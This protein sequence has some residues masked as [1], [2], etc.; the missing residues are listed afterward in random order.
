M[1]TVLHTSIYL[2]A[3]TQNSAREL[4]K[5]AQNAR[6]TLK[7][8]ESLTYE[9]SDGVLL[10][11]LNT[12]LKHVMEE[13]RSK[14]PVAEGLVIRSSIKE[15]VKRAE[16]YTQRIFSLPGY[17]PHGRK[18]ADSAYRNRVGKRADALRK[19]SDTYTCTHM[20]TY[21]CIPVV[22]SLVYLSI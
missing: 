4:K 17:K 7:A 13:F 15:R 6:I 5:E 20:Y 8:I 12:K 21:M 10:K 3:C 19:A 9:C 14:L 2:H 11:E 18:K 1:Y 22:Y 16:K